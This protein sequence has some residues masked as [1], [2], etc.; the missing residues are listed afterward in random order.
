[1]LYIE[2]LITLLLV[3]LMVLS[4]KIVVSHAWLHLPLVDFQRANNTFEIIRGLSPIALTIT[5]YFVF[6]P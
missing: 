5:F 6:R 3:S 4:Q 1:M 2:L